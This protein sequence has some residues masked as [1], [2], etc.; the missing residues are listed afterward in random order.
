[1][2]ALFTARVI[3]IFLDYAFNTQLL[4]KDLIFLILLLCLDKGFLHVQNR[5][6]TTAKKA[7]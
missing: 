7:I 3:F 6:T 4:N 1:M 2:R 5:A